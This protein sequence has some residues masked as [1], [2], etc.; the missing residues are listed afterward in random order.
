MPGLG[1]DL[2]EISRLERALTRHPGLMNRLFTAD[3]RA[4]AAARQSSA[5]H[6]A[7]RFCAKEAVVKALELEAFRPHEIEVLGGD[8]RP[9]RVR[10][11]GRTRERAERLGVSV[12]ISITHSK[13]TAGAVA[14]ALPDA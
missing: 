1:I 7:A 3:E 14:L 11:H 6:L 4:A 12:T 13:D 10:L 9:P 2:L 8:N 5:R